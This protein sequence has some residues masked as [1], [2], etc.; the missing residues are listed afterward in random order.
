MNKNQ[1]ITTKL[2]NLVKK[3]HTP[4]VV[5]KAGSIKKKSS[6]DSGFESDY[7]PTYSDT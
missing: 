3:K 1:N 4:V 5:I 6:S 2:Q 7:F